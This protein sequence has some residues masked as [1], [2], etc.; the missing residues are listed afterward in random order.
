MNYQPKT[1]KRKKMT[2]E[3]LATVEAIEQAIIRQTTHLKNHSKQKWTIE[4][5]ITLIAVLVAMIGGSITVSAVAGAA[6]EKIVSNSKK[7]DRIERQHQEMRKAVEELKK[8]ST[9]SQTNQKHILD[10]VRNIN[11]KLDSKEGD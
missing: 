6:K 3:Q 7:I 10:A 2:D 4:A 11:R 1:P 8:Q 9:V 5:K